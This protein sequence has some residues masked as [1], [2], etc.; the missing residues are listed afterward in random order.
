MHLYKLWIIIY[1][2]V[3]VFPLLIS[4]Q[5]RFHSVQ[6][7]K[8]Y[9]FSRLFLVDSNKVCSDKIQNAQVILSLQVTSFYYAS[10]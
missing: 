10:W 8:P 2:E 5:F 1:I 9:E 7:N 3:L 6:K 4:V